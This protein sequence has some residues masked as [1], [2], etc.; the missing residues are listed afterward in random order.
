MQVAVRHAL[1]GICFLL[2]IAVAT[3]D[4]V[5]LDTEQKAAAGIATALITTDVPRAI[6]IAIDDARTHAD[7]ALKTVQF[8]TTPEALIGA[9]G[10][11]TINCEISGSLRARMADAQP[12]VLR[13]RWNDCVMPWRGYDRTIDG[14]VAITL[15]SD[16]FVPQNVLAIRLGNDAAEYRI[17]WRVE[18]QEQ[19]D[20]STIAF[21]V[22][23]RGDIAM[24]RRWDC[25]EWIGSSSFVMSGYR[26]DQVMIEN[27]VGSTPELIRYKVDAQRMNVIRSTNAVDLLNEDDTHY[28]AGSVTVTQTQ[29][30]PYGTWTEPYKFNNYRIRR[31]YDFSALTEQLSIDGRMNVS[32]SPF[33]GAGCMSGLY[34][35]R[36]RAPLIRQLTTGWHESGEIA[37]NGSAVASFYSSAN[38][39][40]GLPAPV[41]GMLLSLRVSDV[42]TFN[43]D[44]ANW[45]N[46]LVPAGQC[47]L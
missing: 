42:G 3:A 32:W 24:A 29:R 45:Y 19:N 38:T 14:P 43:Y 20:D 18:T 44:A 35:F 17:Q 34:A 33:A 11:I 27:P 7:L 23:L 40:P 13:V 46:A 28:I 4:P 22:A 2:P 21:H 6:N 30:P 26:D 5:P 8:A 16:T 47:R 25:C 31:A 37:V 15:P 9:P 36:T 12:R 41:N 39:P 1:A 10:G